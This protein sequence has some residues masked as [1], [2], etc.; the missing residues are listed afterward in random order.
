ME[1]QTKQK[2]EEY[3]KYVFNQRIAAT[4]LLNAIRNFEALE[5]F[6]GY[7]FVEAELQALTKKLSIIAANPADFS[8]EYFADEWDY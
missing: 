7:I 8:R 1:T 3:Y 2:T 4:K 5:D 6:Q